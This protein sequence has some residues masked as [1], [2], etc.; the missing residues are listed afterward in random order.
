MANALN[1]VWI[2]V[3]VQAGAGSLPNA[4]SVYRRPRYQPFSGAGSTV[5][6]GGMAHLIAEFSALFAG[7]ASFGAVLTIPRDVVATFAGSASF[8][9]KVAIGRDTAATLAGSATLAADTFSTTR[10]P[11]TAGRP[12][13]GQ[14]WPR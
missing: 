8:D 6:A 4:V 2:P 1:L 5:A 14:L 13:I 3:T 12:T 11:P 9:P 10:L 7:S